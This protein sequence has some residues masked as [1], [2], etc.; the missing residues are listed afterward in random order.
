MHEFIITLYDKKE[1]EAFDGM[2]LD[3]KANETEAKLMVDL[4]TVIA[5]REFADTVDEDFNETVIYLNSG[6][7][8]VVKTPYNEVVSLVKKAKQK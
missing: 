1:Q 2:G 8:F 6:E 4:S 3:I 5:I 7:S